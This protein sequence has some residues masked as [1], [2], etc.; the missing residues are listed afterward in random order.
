[1]I[2]YWNFILFVGH[3]IVKA[4]F[5]FPKNWQYFCSK[6][7][8]L[9]NQTAR[10]ILSHPNYSHL[11]RGCSW[12]AQRHPSLFW[13]QPTLNANMHKVRT[14]ATVTNQGWF[15]F[16]GF[17]W[18]WCFLNIV[19]HFL[20]SVSIVSPIDTRQYLIV[21]SN[22]NGTLSAMIVPYWQPYPNDDLNF[23]STVSLE[24]K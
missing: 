12:V 2:F 13:E 24:L 7:T 23:S 14:S 10:P 15:E 17:L 5:H 16:F 6:L 4:P 19:L 11:P 9:S 21:D 20:E 22:D 18:L 1:M 8:F 3:V